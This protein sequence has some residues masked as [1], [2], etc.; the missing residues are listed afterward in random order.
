MPG[1]SCLKRLC[2][3]LKL[4]GYLAITSVVVVLW[5]PV[6]AF[7]KFFRDGM[8][9]TS[10]GQDKVKRLKQRRY[11]DL[12]A[13]RADLVET[14]IEATFE[15]LVQGYIIFPSIISLATRIN[16]SIAMKDGKLNI[17][18]EIDTL[19]LVQLWSII[20]SILSLAWC[21]SDL[22]STKK[23]LQL[24]ICVSPVSRIL[25]CIW[26]ILQLTAR[27]LAFMLFAVYWGPGNIY[28]LMIF[29]AVHIML[30]LVIHLIFSEDIAF[31]KKGRYLKF[32]HNVMLNSFSSMFFHNYLRL[33]QM[34]IDKQLKII[35]N[36]C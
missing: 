30:A 35:S 23:H 14:S 19:E 27:L 20:S 6:T 9:E 31:L 11:D 12:T 33:D 2:H 5:Q 32:F 29:A 16:E 7:I 15:P 22:T 25:M 34:P 26:M 1:E 24:D 4:I 3:L 17:G 28:V 21:Y 8:F 36:F 13:S 18:L 10:S